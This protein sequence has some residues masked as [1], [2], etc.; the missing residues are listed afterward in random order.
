MSEDVCG[1][2]LRENMM[3]KLRPKQADLSEYKDAI[4]SKAQ[5]NKDE[6]RWLVNRPTWD[7]LFASQAASDMVDFDGRMWVHGILVEVNDRVPTKTAWI[8]HILEVVGDE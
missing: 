4:V 3:E 5:F 7:E 6:F 8:V 2:K 1:W